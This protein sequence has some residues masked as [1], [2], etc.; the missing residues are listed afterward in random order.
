VCGIEAGEVHQLHGHGAWGTADRVGKG[1]YF[2]ISAVQFAKGNAAIQVEAG[3][4]L[5][6]GPV[7][8]FQV[9]LSSDTKNRFWI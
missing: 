9:D 7:W 3:Q 4:R 1:D 5:L 6:S 8:V 2:G